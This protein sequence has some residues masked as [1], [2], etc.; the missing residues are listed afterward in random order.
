MNQI[1]KIRELK[2]NMSRLDSILLGDNAFYGIDHLSHERA[3]ERVSSVQSIENAVKII[4]FS[5]EL[6][7]NGMVVATRP[8]LREWIEHLRKTS[9]LVDKLDFYPV[10]PYARGLQMKLSQLGMVK[11]MNEL[12]KGAGIKKEIKFLTRGGLGFLKKDMHELFRVFIDTEMLKLDMIKPKIIFLHPVL[13][14]LSLALKIKSIFE[15]FSDHLKNNYNINTGLCTKNF[16]ML[17][18]RLDEWNLKFSSIMTSF[19][20]AGFLMNPSKKECEEA[21]NNYNGNVLAMNIF[22]GGYSKVDEA[23]SYILSQQKIR[24]LV[25]GVSSI[26]H[27]KETFG[28]LTKA[29]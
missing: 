28:L 6:G 1:K 13:V 21:L 7:A 2:W 17:V 24:N 27:A 16:P 12:M 11:T 15:T 19:N 29:T 10:M 4:K 5:Y 9:D 26:E 14:D 3:R 20:P 23:I 8:R 25:V 18:S 22:A